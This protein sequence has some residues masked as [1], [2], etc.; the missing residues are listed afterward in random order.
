M[1][2][3]RQQAEAKINSLPLSYIDKQPRGDLLSRVTNDVDNIANTLQ[4]SATQ[5]LTSVVSIIGIIIMMLTISPWLTL[6]ALVVLGGRGQ[7][8]DDDEDQ[9]DEPEV[10]LG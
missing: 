5:I 2:R 4:Q 7:E 3:L 1:F 8:A 9:D 6:I 10:A